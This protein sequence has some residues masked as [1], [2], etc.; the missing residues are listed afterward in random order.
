MYLEVNVSTSIL[1]DNPRPD[2]Q[3]CYL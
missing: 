1:S 2:D 3:C